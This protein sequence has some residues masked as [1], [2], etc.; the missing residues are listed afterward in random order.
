MR[1]ADRAKALLEPTIMSRII[2]PEMPPVVATQPIASGCG[3]HFV[4][5]SPLWRVMEVPKIAPQ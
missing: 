5:S 2:S 4:R 3:Q 1:R